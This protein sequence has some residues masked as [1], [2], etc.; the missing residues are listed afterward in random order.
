MLSICAAVKILQLLRLVGQ[1][2]MVPL[3]SRPQ[4][5]STCIQ[6]RIGIGGLPQEIR[7]LYGS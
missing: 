5:L 1:W 2:L 7:S 4:R 6:L 3:R